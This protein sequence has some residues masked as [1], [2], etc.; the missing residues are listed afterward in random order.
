MLLQLI[1]ATAGCREPVHQRS[2]ALGPPVG[3]AAL[4]FVA[5]L[6][7]LGTSSRVMEQ[8]QSHCGGCTL[9]SNRC[10]F[11]ERLTLRLTLAFFFF[12]MPFPKPL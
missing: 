2:Q 9:L 11:P 7:H 5:L 3:L 12:H 4:W 10:C 1:R 6:I 8:E